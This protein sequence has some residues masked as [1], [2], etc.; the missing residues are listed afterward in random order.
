MDTSQVP[1]NSWQ[2]IAVTADGTELKLFRNGVEVASDGSGN[3]NY[4][5]SGNLNIARAAWAN[6]YFDGKISQVSL[7]DKTL[8]Q[9]EIQT[10]M[11]GSPEITDANLLG[12]WSLNE[13]SETTA[14]DRSSNNNDGTITGAIWVDTAPKIYGNHPEH[15]SFPFFEQ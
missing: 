12:Y 7:W 2:F 14:E 1:L 3:S 13:G 5:G 15:E 4:T 10:L 6:D 8:S 11:A 9:S